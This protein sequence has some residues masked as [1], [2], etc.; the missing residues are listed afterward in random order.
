[1]QFLPVNEMFVS[2]QTEGPF[3]GFPAVF[4]RLAGCNLTCSFCDTDHKKNADLLVRDIVNFI[5]QHPN[6]PL[7]VITGGEPFLHDLTNL[8]Y[9]IPSSK[10]V[11]IETNGTVKPQVAG[12]IMD[13]CVVVCSPK[14]DCTLHA[15]MVNNHIN[16][17][18]ILVDAGTEAKDIAALLPLNVTNDQIFL[19]PVFVGEGYTSTSKKNIKRAVELCTQTGYKL[20][21]QYHKIIGIQ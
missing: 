10:I 16:Y 21:L 5:N 8:V 20:S 6:I 17:Y 7:V 18:K 3:S 15:D 12:N 2:I 13:C 11:Q 19:Q 9:M 1:M 4:V 14:V